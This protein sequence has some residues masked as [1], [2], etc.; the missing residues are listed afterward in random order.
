[1][2]TLEYV[3]RIWV[4]AEHAPYRHLPAFV[5]RRKYILSGAGIVDLIS[6]V[7]FW[8][9]LLVPADLRAILVLRVIR[10]LKIAR[11][12]SGDALCCSMCCMASAA[13]CSAA[14]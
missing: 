12:S 3:A 11:Y 14:W 6:V 8:F 7:P 13:R 4:A 9:G 10:F 1:M 5:A 2:F